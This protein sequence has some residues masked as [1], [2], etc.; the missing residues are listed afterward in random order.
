ML[1]E[2][3]FESRITEYL[4][5][6]FFSMIFQFVINMYFLIRKITIS[7]RIEYNTWSYI[8]ERSINRLLV[9]DLGKCGFRKLVGQKPDCSEKVEGEE[10]KNEKV[11]MF[12]V[13]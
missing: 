1:T 4:N 10:G 3:I 5:F 12:T 2:A 9:S 13:A 11:N 7:K 8:A 6:P